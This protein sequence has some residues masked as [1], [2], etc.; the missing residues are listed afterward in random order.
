MS[1]KTHYGRTEELIAK[2]AGHIEQF[3]PHMD[4]F[5]YEEIAPIIEEMYEWLES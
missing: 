5:L 1:E 3:L 2:W 4:K